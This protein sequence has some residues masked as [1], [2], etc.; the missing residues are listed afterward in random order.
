M[1]AHPLEP[2]ELVMR[3]LKRRL[4]IPVAAA[5]LISAVGIVGCTSDGL[6]PHETHGQNYSALIYSTPRVQAGAEAQAAAATAVT[7]PQ[8]ALTTVAPPTTGAGPAAHGTLAPATRP[9]VRAPAR[10]AVAQV[11]EVAP[12]HVM[13]DELRSHDRLFDRVEPLAG[14]FELDSGQTYNEGAYPRRIDANARD[15]QLSARRM[16][17]LQFAARDMGMDYLLIL[18]GTVDHAQ[19]TSPLS[20][21]NLTIIGL[22]VVPS[23]EVRISGKAAASLIDLRNGQVVFNVSS[24]ADSSDWM[25]T[26]SVQAG[27]QRALEGIRD[28]L[29][30]KLSKEVV[31]QMEQ[32]TAGGGRT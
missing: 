25:P 30:H 16:E 32:E 20:V 13:L 24:D 6:S 22:F 4:V 19:N 31:R 12:S 5:S 29:V 1:S 18:G 28:Q 11:G 9:V 7:P 2:R 15:Q 21:L 17:E 27:Q 3:I 8:G 23:E 10:V 14:V 26:V